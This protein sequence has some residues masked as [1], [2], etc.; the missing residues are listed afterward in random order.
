[1]GKRAKFPVWPLAVVLGLTIGAVVV[2]K[3]GL[4]QKLLNFSPQVPRDFQETDYSQ[5]E[6]PPE[7]DL[8]YSE[9][10]TYR[11]PKYNYEIKWRQQWHKQ[12]DNEPPYPPPPASM[13]FSRKFSTNP[14]EICDYSILAFDGADNFNAEIESL[15][16]D[17]THTQ[18]TKTIAGQK[19]TAFLINNDFQRVE[20]YYFTHKDAAFRMGYNFIK[21]SRTQ[22]E[23]L[24]TFEK[25]TQSFKFLD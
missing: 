25:M 16:K 20:T 8:D 6:I 3:L 15:K 5:K 23:C 4:A 18:S 9:F 24:P 19:A 1:M 21:T 11:N 12:A 10:L 17:S 7:S 2:W 14:P 22:Q 13:T